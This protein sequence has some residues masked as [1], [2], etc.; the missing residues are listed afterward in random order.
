[1]SCLRAGEALSAILL[2]A[3][4]RRLAT[5]I[6]SQ[7]V[8]VEAARQIFEDQV[9]D[10]TKSAQLLIRVGWP[11]DDAEIPATPRRETSDVLTQRYVPTAP[12]RTSLHPGYKPVNVKQGDES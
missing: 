5:R 7:V 2:E 1:M 3:T 4:R 9:L 10:G 6:D 8:E 12:E 11:V